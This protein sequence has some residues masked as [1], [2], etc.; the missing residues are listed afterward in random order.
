[1]KD[2]PS[3]HAFIAS[4][5]GGYVSA[6]DVEDDLALA[7]NHVAYSDSEEEAIDNMTA[8]AGYKW[9]NQP[10]LHRLKYASPLSRAP[11]SFKRCNPL[12]RRVTSR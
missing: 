8:T 9:Q 4:N 10:E 6:S 2:C 5:G 11:M 7:A 1:M 3:H 12:A